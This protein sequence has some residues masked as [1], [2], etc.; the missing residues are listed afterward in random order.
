MTSTSTRARTP[1][2]LERDG[3]QAL[4]TSADVA[5]GFYDAVLAEDVLM[6]L[7]GGL[8]LDDREQVL[9]TMSGPP[10]THHELHDV[11]ALG[12]SDDCVVV[13]YRV[14]AEREGAPYDALMS[15]TYVRRDGAWRLALH[16]Q[17]PL[18]HGS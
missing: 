16:Q 17:T 1:E 14:H 3:W 5:R 7:P 2:L 13:T 18:L 11:R 4:S 12:L 8:V 9:A 10:W 15:S 6:L